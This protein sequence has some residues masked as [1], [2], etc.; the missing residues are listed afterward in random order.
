MD[1][2]PVFDQVNLVVRDMARAV[3][4]YRLLG[5][6][7]ADSDTE[8]DAHH[9]NARWE[10][11][12]AGHLGLDLDS[13]VFAQR[14]DGG[15]PADT[16][17]VVLGF[18]V[19]EG[20]TVDEIYERMTSAGHPSQQEPCDAEW[21]ARFAVVTDPEGNAVGIQSARDPSLARREPPPSA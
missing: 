14:W 2:R 20:S 10:G 6:D 17:G 3:E 19:A 8:W 4:F 12:G 7:I 18:R 1:D 5:V 21:G 13:Q 15:W 9:R 11:G 16:S